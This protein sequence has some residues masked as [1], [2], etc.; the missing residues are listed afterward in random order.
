MIRER[1]EYIVKLGA[2]TADERELAQHWLDT[3]WHDWPQEK[4]ERWPVF[5]RFRNV[6]ANDRWDYY[7]ALH[8]EPTKSIKQWM[9]IPE[10]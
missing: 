6:M 9:Y 8:L 1:A 3:Q 7:C 5:V 10:G 2:V 4:P